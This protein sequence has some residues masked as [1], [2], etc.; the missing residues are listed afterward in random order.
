VARKTKETRPEKKLVSAALTEYA[1]VN[2]VCHIATDGFSLPDDWGVTTEIRERTRRDI[3][4]VVQNRLVDF[5]PKKIREREL[6]AN[7]IK[8][9]GRLEGLTARGVLASQK[10]GAMKIHFDWQPV[11]TDVETLIDFGLALMLD[12]KRPQFSR[13]RR[14]AL[15][16]CNKYFI[17]INTRSGRPTHFCSPEHSDKQRSIDSTIRKREL[18][19]RMKK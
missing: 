13:V 1:C 11:I 8:Y 16:S 4:R 19:A 17:Q 15:N 2:F 18:R 10:T 5:G 14:C 7:R 6:V 9:D 3:E 12:E